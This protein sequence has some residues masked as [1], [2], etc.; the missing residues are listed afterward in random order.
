MCSNGNTLQALLRVDWWL[1]GPGSGS[2]VNHFQPVNFWYVTVKEPLLMSLVSGTTRRSSAVLHKW[3]E[4][5]G[6]SDLASVNPHMKFGSRHVWNLEG[7]SLQSHIFTHEDLIHP[8]RFL[9]S[10][11]NIYDACWPRLLRFSPTFWLANLRHDL[12]PVTWGE[13]SR[14]S[15]F[16]LFFC[17]LFLVI[18]NAASICA[19]GII[20]KGGG[21]AIL[22][23]ANTQPDQPG[24]LELQTGEGRKWREESEKSENRSTLKGILDN[25]EDHTGC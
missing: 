4:Y 21:G 6:V 5:I 16:F 25:R 18:L 13:T 1:N 24:Q 11:S 15:S 23:P 19:L 7:W 20:I 14:I 2:N 12:W 17:G 22:Q 3:C 8:W 9:W 10:R